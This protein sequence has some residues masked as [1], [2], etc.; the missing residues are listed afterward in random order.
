[1]PTQW[2]DLELENSL[3]LQ[4]EISE[5]KKQASNNLRN[6]REEIGVNQDT[7][8]KVMGVSRAAL[9]Y[10][11]NGSR[12]P[13]IDFINMVHLR[14]SCDL[15][16]LLGSGSIMRPQLTTLGL[17]LDKNEIQANNLMDLCTHKSFVAL[18]NSD[19]FRHVLSL[20]EEGASDFVNGKCD[21]SW[22]MFQC[23]KVM[24][25]IFHE[26]YSAHV[27]ELLSDPNKKKQFE[28][29]HL[30]QEQ[31]RRESYVHETKEKE[32][33]FVQANKALK[34]LNIRIVD[35]P[36]EAFRYKMERYENKEAD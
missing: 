18:F 35:N 11:E 1:M 22:T 5:R 8:A 7:F 25:Q 34:D 14:T 15:S 33:H 26:M 20:L 2:I 12:T 21:Y 6:L 36:F 17:A 29:L 10:Y 32:E 24:E 31:E 9:S 19:E 3:F 16:Y 27:A 30:K 4:S 13:D 28:E 23:F